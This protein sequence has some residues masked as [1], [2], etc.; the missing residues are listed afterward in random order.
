VPSRHLTEFAFPEFTATHSGARNKERKGEKEG[1]K[2]KKID[3][4]YYAV[5]LVTVLACV[6]ARCV[7][8]A[9]S[10]YG[11]VTP[12]GNLFPADLDPTFQRAWATW[13]RSVLRADSRVAVN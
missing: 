2:R 10:S 12:L 1:R 13:C 5:R 3:A 7:S 4:I 9:P 6:V 11:K 8:I